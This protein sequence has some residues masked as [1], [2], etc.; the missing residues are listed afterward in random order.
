MRK[1]AAVMAGMLVPAL[2]TVAACPAL[3][4]DKAAAASVQ[5][6]PILENDKV[7]VYELNYAPGAENK[8]VASSSVRIVRA[9]KGGTL[10]RTYVDSKKENVEWKANQVRQLEAT[11]AYT[12]KNTGKTPVQ[13]YIVL[14]K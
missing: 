9:L 5:T 10:T 3:A 13:L 7:K 8:A 2:L 4:Q 14:L 12:T 11:P 1:L 6:K